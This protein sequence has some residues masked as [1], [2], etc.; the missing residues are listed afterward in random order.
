[1]RQKRKKMVSNY[2]AAYNKNM[3]LSPISIFEYHSRT[4][5]AYDVPV[6]MRLQKINVMNRC[7]ITEL[8]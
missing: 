6:V 2:K 7:Q 8:I 4:K 5:F 3:F 1:M